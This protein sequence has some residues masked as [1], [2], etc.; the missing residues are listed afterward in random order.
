MDK[1][2]RVAAIVMVKNEADIIESFARHVLC[3]ADV[4][5]VADHLST[6]ATPEILTA[7]QKEGLALR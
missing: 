3:L 6:D 5:L 2:N 7:L 4:L 1:E